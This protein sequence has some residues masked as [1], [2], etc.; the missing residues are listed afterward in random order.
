MP[1]FCWI[2]SSTPSSTITFW[3][4]ERIRFYYSFQ[5]GLYAIDV[6]R[7][8]FHQFQSK[9]NSRWPFDWKTPVGYFVVWISQCAG[10]VAAGTTATLFFDMIFGSC[11]LFIVIAQDITDDVIAFNKTVNAI[12]NTERIAKLMEEF[13]DL[14]TYYLDAKQWVV[15]QFFPNFLSQSIDSCIWSQVRQWIQSNEEVFTVY[16]LFVVH[17]VHIQ[18]TDHSTISISWVFL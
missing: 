14:I 7:N 11:W 5:L 2:H 18:S 13:S 3:I 6:K 9:Q 8:K 1:I 12:E 10:I 4:R 15:A 17:F 16:I